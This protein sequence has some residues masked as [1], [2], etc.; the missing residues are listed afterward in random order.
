MAEKKP[1]ESCGRVLEEL[2]RELAD[3]LESAIEEA[4][5]ESVSDDAIQMG[6]AIG[7]HDQASRTLDWLENFLGSRAIGVQGL[8]KKTVKLLGSEGQWITE[9]VRKD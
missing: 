6:I 4:D 8:R 7:R 3:F 1:K 9:I 2:V 5:K